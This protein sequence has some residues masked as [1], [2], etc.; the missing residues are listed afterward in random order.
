MYKPPATH[1]EYMAEQAAG[2]ARMAAATP[3]QRALV[4]AVQSHA[5]AHYEQG[6]WDFVLECWEEHDIFAYLAEADFDLDKAIAEIGWS[7][8]VIDDYRT[9]IQNA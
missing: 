7:V 6:G 8:G 4:G 5:Q 3:E 2:K 9:E 1:D